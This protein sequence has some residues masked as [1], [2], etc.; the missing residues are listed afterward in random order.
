[1]TLRVRSGVSIIGLAL[2]LSGCATGKL[3][4]YIKQTAAPRPSALYNAME[5]SAPDGSKMVCYQLAK[6][7]DG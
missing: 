3:V 5:T 1:V 2:T 7:S 4:A 6:N